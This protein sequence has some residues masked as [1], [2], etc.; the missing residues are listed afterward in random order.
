MMLGHVRDFFARLAL[1]LPGHSGPVSVEFVVDT[2][3]EGELALPER[4]INQL[5]VSD[6]SQRPV[7]LADGTR[8]ER[9]F[10]KIVLDWHDGPRLVELLTLEGS[11]LLGVELL[12]DSLLQAEMFDG[13]EVSV[14]PL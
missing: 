14:E 5:A 7:L 8:R 2:G 10:H 4:L 12:A 1:T 11:P 6:A 13:G 9:P 3:F